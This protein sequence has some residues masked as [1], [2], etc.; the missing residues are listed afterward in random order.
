LAEVAEGNQK[1]WKENQIKL[2]HLVLLTKIQ[3]QEISEN[4][5]L[6]H[7]GRLNQRITNY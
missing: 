5:V 7:P 2:K 6:R 4:E 1:Q 3:F